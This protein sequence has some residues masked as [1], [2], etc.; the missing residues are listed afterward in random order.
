VLPQFT[1][2]ARLAISAVS[3]VQTPLTAL[4][5]GIERNL[6]PVFHVTFS[7][8]VLQCFCAAKVAGFFTRLRRISHQR[9]RA[10]L[11]GISVLWPKARA[12][13]GSAAFMV[14]VR[15]KQTQLWN[16]QYNRRI[17]AMNTVVAHLAR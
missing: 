8:I 16:R 9:H 13:A 4:M 1:A 12:C 15:L 3:P 17:S 2:R 7:V 11:N 10:R 5:G 14:I 6:Y